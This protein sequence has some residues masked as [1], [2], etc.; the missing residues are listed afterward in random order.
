MRRRASG[1]CEKGEAAS[2]QRGIEAVGLSAIQPTSYDQF[3][4]LLG[5]FGT[6]GRNCGPKQWP[7]VADWCKSMNWFSACLSFFPVRWM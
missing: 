3:W 6:Y 2:P 7:A 4:L 1:G 5:C